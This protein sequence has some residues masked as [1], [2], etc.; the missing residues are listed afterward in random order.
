MKDIIK[1]GDSEEAQDDGR[2]AEK[3]YIPHHSIYLPKK[4]E[5]LYVVFNCSAKQKGTN[6]NKNYLHFLWLKNGD[7]SPQP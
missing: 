3:W 1:I 2:P 6:L 5:K 7:S 4:L